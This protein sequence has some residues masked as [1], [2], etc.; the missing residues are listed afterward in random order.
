MLNEKQIAEI[1]EHL[2]QA[3]N[4]IF[5]F[6]NDVDGL[7]S[8]LLLRRYSEKGKG[9]AIKSFPELDLAHFK[10][11]QELDAD[12]IFVLDKPL[13]SE[14]FFEEAEKFNIP[15][16]WI[17]HHQ[18]PK[19]IPNL[20]SY[21][22]PLLNKKNKN[23]AF[24]EPTT[25]LCYQISQRKSDM[26]IATVG[27][28]SDGFIPDFYP[29]FL[30]KYG[31]LGKKGKNSLEIV[32]ESQLGKI[33]RILSFALKDRTTNVVNMIKFLIK[34]KSPYDVLEEENQN[35]SMHQRFNEIDLKYKRL[36]EKAKS[37]FNTNKKLLF[38]RYGGNLSISADLATKLY[39]EFPDKYII[40]AYDSGVK[41]NISGRGKGIRPLILNAIEGFESATGGGHG[42]AVGAKV[43]SKDADKFK[44]QL[45][46]FVE[47][48]N[49]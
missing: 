24:G 39:Y 43:F 9:I 30:E 10:K 31:D 37:Q 20:V 14:E 28:F 41:L 46:M 7:C 29:D 36:I 5:F 16:V 40:V 4:P 17:D 19:K 11:V 42:D 8:F 2:D 38:F 23:S 1:R 35:S 6:D 15:I 26:W 44:E 12:Y 49:Q 13:I 45:E 33:I 18:I 22:N 27:S 34:S 21:Y 3:Q 32:Y 25:F 48:E 47:E